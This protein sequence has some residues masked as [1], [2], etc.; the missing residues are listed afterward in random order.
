M[1]VPLVDLRAA[2][3]PVKEQ[4]FREFESI[5]D[6]MQLF[7]GPNT[8]AFEEEFAAYCGAAHGLGVSNGTDALFA[9]L[10]ACG[11]GPGDEVIAPAHTFFATIEA[12]VHTGATPVLAD[13][14][15]DTLTLDPA[16]VRALVTDRTRAIVPVHLYGQ[17]ADMDPI[18]EIARERGL[19]VVED[20]AQAHGAG[21]KGRRCGSLGDAASFSF[22]FTK[23]LGGVGEGGFVTTSDAAIAEQVRLLR[24]HGHVSKFEHAIIGYNLRLDELQ[25]AVLRAKLPG[26]DAGNAQRRAHAAHYD[27]LFAGSAVQVPV[28]RPG[29]RA[30]LPRL[31]AARAAPRRARRAPGRARRRHRHPL[32]ESGPPPARAAPPP[33]PRRRHEGHDRGV[34][35]ADLAADVSAAHARA[36]GVRGRAGAR[37]RQRLNSAPRPHRGG[38]R[39]LEL[40]PA[41][42]MIAQAVARG[43]LIGQRPYPTRYERITVLD[44]QPIAG[45]D[46]SVDCYARNRVGSAR[47]SLRSIEAH[48]RILRPRA[49]APGL[50]TA[51]HQTRCRQ[52]DRRR[53]R[54]PDPLERRLHPNASSW[55][56]ER[57][58]SRVGEERDQ[59]WPRARRLAMQHVGAPRLRG[60]TLASPS[61]SRALPIRRSL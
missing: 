6:G 55:P 47:P 52:S 56:R 61:P 54:H 49:R 21:Y 26:L 9:A 15:R 39:P 17:A 13:V 22:Y 7:Q 31:R 40:P 27:A 25:A 50:I 19:R 48:V 60:R 57:P 2:F 58:S 20:A 46:T 3:A 12:I 11:V 16:A 36:G 30:R 59:P 33:A 38:S 43:A 4:V 35:R 41:R 23:N 14:E 32:Q 44:T 34:P 10:L 29:Q 51:R 42:G 8:V 53:L 45:R 28:C 1:N 37:V 18:L 5:L 24:H